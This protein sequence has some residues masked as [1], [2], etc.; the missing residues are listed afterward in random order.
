MG[1]PTTDDRRCLPWHK[2]EGEIVMR[3]Y[4]L[5]L[6]A[7]AAAIGL[8]VSAASAADL[9]RKAPVYA[10]PPPPPF[11][12]TG[13]YIGAH[14]GAG[15]GTVEATADSLCFLGGCTVNPGSNAFAQT[16]LNGWLF[17]G[18]VGY[19]WQVNPWLVLG[20]EGDY[21]WTNFEGTSPCGPTVLTFEFGGN[22]HS[23]V[24]YTADFTGRV[25]FAVDKAL[26][27]IKGGVVWAKSD[28]D[29]NTFEEGLCLICVQ[30]SKTRTGGLFGAGI[31]Y[32]FLPNWSAKIEYNYMDF[33]T[34][35]EIV[36][37]V[38]DVVEPVTVNSQIREVIHT[39]KAGVNYRF[40][41]GRMGKAPY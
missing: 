41:W 1:G 13:F 5:T 30:L 4:S 40:D 35:N 38:F 20:L 18:T 39:V 10:P 17:G 12:W 19:N 28:H 25:G 8:A 23:K 31:E 22:C 11:S 2:S 26:I 9:P 6:L 21:D 24:K 29:A 37:G 34:H 14:G 32:A 16:Q 27:Y 15:W 33:G 7:A 36:A 3:K